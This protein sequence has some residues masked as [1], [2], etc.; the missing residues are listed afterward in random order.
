MEKLLNRK[1]LLFTFLI[2]LMF[3]VVAYACMGRIG[4]KVSWIDDDIKFTASVSTTLYVSKLN[5]ISL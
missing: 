1:I 2:I 4:G 3:T 5:E